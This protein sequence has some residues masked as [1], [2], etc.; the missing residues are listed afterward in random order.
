MYGATQVQA[1]VARCRSTSQHVSLALKR[2]KLWT[3]S[4]LWRKETLRNHNKGRNRQLLDTL[5]CSVFGVK[6]V[7]QQTDIQTAEFVM[8][9]E[10]L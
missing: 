1:N 7:K 5:Q 8:P 6:C 4:V 2:V 3:L 9:N 10:V